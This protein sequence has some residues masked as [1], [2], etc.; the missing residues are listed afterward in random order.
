MLLMATLIALAAVG[1]AH[2]VEPPVRHCPTAAD[3]MHGAS[4]L[5]SGSSIAESLSSVG[6]LSDAKMGTTEVP[7]AAQVLQDH[8]FRSALDL[9]LL[10]PGTAEAAEL[11]EKLRLGGV[12]IAD[13]SKVRLFIEEPGGGRAASGVAAGASQRSVGRWLGAVGKAGA[14]QPRQLQGSGNSGS[15]NLSM[16]TVHSPRNP[17]VGL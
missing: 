14:R 8:G 5:C 4:Q 17:S 7:M 2:A 10:Q 6:V 1:L 16:D 12:T 15:G 9:R 3:V 13:R 11:M